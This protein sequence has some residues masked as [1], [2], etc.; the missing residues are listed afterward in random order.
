MGIKFW[1]FYKNKKQIKIANIFELH[2]IMNSN[3][4]F[5]NFALCKDFYKV[6]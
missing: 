2:K 1:N 4:K 3:K 5:H 6:L